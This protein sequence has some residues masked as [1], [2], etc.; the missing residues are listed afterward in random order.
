MS[1]QVRPAIVGRVE[2]TLVDILAMPWPWIGAAGTLLIAAVAQVGLDDRFLTSIAI[3][4]PLAFV[5]RLPRAAA[6]VAVV[7]ALGWL[8]PRAQPIPVGAGAGLMIV[9][10]VAAYRLTAIDTCVIGALFLVNAV[11]PFNSAEPGAAGYLLLAVVTAALGLGRLLRSRNAIIAEHEALAVAHTST[12]RERS[13]LVDRAAIAREL[14]DVVAHHISHIAIQAETARYTTPDL[15]E[16]A[17]TRLAAIGESARDALAEMRR[18]LTVIRSPAPPRGGA[19]VSQPESARAPRP[20]LDQLSALIEATRVLG[21]V[22]TVT[23]SGSPAPLPAG[24]D[25]VSYRVIQEA[26]TN[27]RRHAPGAD[28]DIAV[29]YT[30]C[31][32]RLMINNGAPDLALPA[33]SAGLGLVGMRERVDAVGGTL[34][35]GHR[36]DGGFEVVAEL[37]L[38]RNR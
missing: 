37:P 17:G 32:L 19:A 18:I 12:L 36:T 31:L 26:L 13:I 14:H 21:T 30:P 9:C 4:V 24:T 27:A 34:R 23:V 3:A 22:V 1:A 35:H 7:A 6:A 15:P 38:R 20:G 28:V 2:G 16:L 5:V 33:D 29:D 25:L 10:A 11:T 8:F